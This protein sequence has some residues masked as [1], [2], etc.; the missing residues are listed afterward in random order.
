MTKRKPYWQMKP[1]EL[2]NVTSQFNLPNVVAQ[3]RSLTA[4][5]RKQWNAAKRKRGR[6]KIGQGHK[7]VSLSMEQGLLNQVTA[8]ARKQRISR[9]QLFAQVLE[10]ALAREK[11]GCREK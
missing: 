8:M 5:E 6:P 9:S 2:A 7:R 3:S 4:T 11:N 1:E 10:E